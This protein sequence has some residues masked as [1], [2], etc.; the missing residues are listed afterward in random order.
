MAIFAGDEWLLQRFGWVQERAAREAVALCGGHH[1]SWNG[2]LPTIN[3]KAL[4]SVFTDGQV[5]FDRE[6]VIEPILE[7]FE[8]PGAWRDPGRLAVCRDAFVTVLHE[9]NHLVSPDGHDYVELTAVGDDPSSTVMDEGTTELWAQVAADRFLDG[10]GA[11]TYAP[12]IKGAVTAPAYPQYVP[13]ID[14]LTKRV[15][16][17]VGRPHTHVLSLLNRQTAAGK[18]PELARV[19]LA[20]T[21]LDGAIPAHQRGTR[22]REIENALR[23]VFDDVRG[24]EAARTDEERWA[25]S[26]TMGRQASLELDAMI[27]RLRRQYDTGEPGPVSRPR[28]RLQRPSTQPRAMRSRPRSPRPDHG[29]ER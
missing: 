13:A 1:S 29:M 20:G 24:I 28:E 22:R 2:R 16:E 6:Q 11:E 3:R 21:G 9:N 12:G 14:R 19:V 25:I 23:E 15:G 10:F 17:L 18:F 5:S 27:E 26:Q 7:V 4:G 8:R